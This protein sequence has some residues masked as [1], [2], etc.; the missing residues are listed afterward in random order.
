MNMGQV[1]WQ[2]PQTDG[3]ATDP[4]ALATAEPAP[5]GEPA[6]PYAPRSA[7]SK[8]VF[9]SSMAIAPLLIATAPRPGGR[10]PPC[11][12]RRIP[13]DDCLRMARSTQWR[14]RCETARDEGVRPVRMKKGPCVPSGGAAS[15]L[16]LSLFDIRLRTRLSSS[17]RR[18]TAL[19]MKDEPCAGARRGVRSAVQCVS[20]ID[21]RTA[22]GA[23]RPPRRVG[24]IRSANRRPGKADAC[25]PCPPSPPC[26]PRSATSSNSREP[27]TGEPTSSRRSS[28]RGFCV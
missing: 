11:T 13:W 20:W 21:C 23:P 26:P 4:S 19:R 1:L 14:T 15:A 17:G 9:P 10:P 16:R 18:A 6:P 27:G 2:P 3:I 24:S 5:A 28:W 8:M 7:S 22:L 12:G 25:P